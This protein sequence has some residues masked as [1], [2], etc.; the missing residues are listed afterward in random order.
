MDRRQRRIAA[1]AVLAAVVAACSAPAPTAHLRGFHNG[2]SGDDGGVVFGEDPSGVVGAACAKT[3]AAASHSPVY[4]LVVLDGS[5]SMSQDNKWYAVVPALQAFF[6][7][8]ARHYDPSFGVGLTV[9]SDTLDATSGMGP[10]G[11]ADV[12][13]RVVDATQAA[14]LVARLTGAPNGLTP[15]FAVMSGQYPLL[16]SFE[17]VAPLEAGGKRVLVLMTDGVPNAGAPEQEQCV[18]LAATE[19]TKS[20]LT[21]AVGIG[22]LGQYDPANYDPVF[23][24]N[25]AVAGGAPNAGCVPGEKTDAAR[26]CHFQVTPGGRSAQEIERDFLGAID[27]IRGEALSCDFRLP[28]R[29]DDVDP[30]KVNV[31][32]TSGA[33]KDVLLPQNATDGWTFDDAASPTSVLLH[34]AAC[35]AA[36]SDPRGKVSIVMGCKTVVR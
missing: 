7:D 10:Y 12:P 2:A 19:R 29:T 3:T 15:T 30:Q 22:N 16:D 18:A 26:M 6:D 21:F 27:R 31:V 4:M 23:M 13:I 35:T 32:F 5:G 20:T 33:G 25:L 9:F 36:K 24:A 8:L 11:K 1:A 17:P 34:G 14:A 28:P